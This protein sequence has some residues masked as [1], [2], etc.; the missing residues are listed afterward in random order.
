MSRDRNRTFHLQ[1]K[2]AKKELYRP[3]VRYDRPLT[4][5]I[6]HI[7]KGRKYIYTV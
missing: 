7:Y 1:K 5:E 2:D 6:L 4:H 3:N